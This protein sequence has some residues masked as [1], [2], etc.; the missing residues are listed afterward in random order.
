MSDAARL[1]RRRVSSASGDMTRSTRGGQADL[2]VVDDALRSVS[3]KDANIYGMLVASADGLVLATDTRDIHVETVAAMA[4]AAASIAIQ[5][6]SQADIGDSRAS[7][8]E[9]A[10]GYVAVFPVEPSVL[11]VVFGQKDLTMGMFNIAAR[12]ALAALQEAIRR[13]RMI[14]AREI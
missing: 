8:F 10:T 12:N 2:S 5:F 3:G 14:K 11:L 6:T 7:I 4:A 13:R 1:P 9:G